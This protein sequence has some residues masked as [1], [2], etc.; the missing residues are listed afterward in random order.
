VRYGKNLG[1]DANFTSQIAESVI[2][3]YANV[4]P[5]LVEQKEIIL[6]EL[7]TEESK[8]RAT[9]EKGLKEFEK[10]IS[11]KKALTAEDVFFLY[12]TY[13]FPYE[14]TKEEAQ[15]RET[16]V[17]TKE[18]F[19]K[20]AEKHRELSRTASAGMFKGGLQEHSEITTKYHTATHLLHAA[21]RQILG[22]HVQQ[23]GSNIT[24]ER[25]RFDFSH[26]EKV[27]EEQLKEIEDLVN[28]QIEAELPV[29]C[30]TLD[31]EE[32]LRS[33]AL[34]LFTDKYGD[35]VTVYSIGEFSKEICGGP[36]VQNTKELG[37][38]Q[39]TKE[40][41]AGAGVRRIYATLS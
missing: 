30:Q 24:G 7:T 25:M 21:L 20:K 19:E 18:E 3:I 6:K 2:E 5:Y 29:I 10:L 40:E 34:G 28:H 12:E 36:H 4:F 26:P 35:K 23:K 14:L 37:Y 31:K 13:G 9:I 41:S 32:A 8:F 11:G 16:I 27:T 22:T 38:F 17:A 15:K 39:I 33:G 1:I